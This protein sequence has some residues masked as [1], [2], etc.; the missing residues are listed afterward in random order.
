MK[1]S[2]R[3]FTVGLALVAAVLA[4][5]NSSVNSPIRIGDGETVSGSLST[6]NGTITVGTD[7]T[8]GGTCRAVNGLVDIG[9]RTRVEGLTTV[10]GSI[11]THEGVRVEG[12]VE[13]VNGPIRLGDG[14][15]VEGDVSTINGA[16]E[17]VATTAMRDVMTVN[18]DVRLLRRS[19]V[20]GD[21]VIKDKMGSSSRNQPL[22]IEI[23]E[24][25]TVEGS[26]IVE[27]E[28]LDVRVI[29]RGGGSVTGSI[30]GAEVVNEET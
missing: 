27:D 14:T 26:I 19:V 20:R 24:G 5:C 29:L 16:I 23:A 2:R 7:T 10:N 1:R 9:A 30:K 28:D 17:M 3:S 6:G 13:S 18:G 21:V 12:E 8:I 15:E 25:S 4:A 22:R 11:R